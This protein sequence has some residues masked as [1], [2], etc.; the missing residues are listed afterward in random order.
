MTKR[1]LFPVISGIA[2][3]L[4]CTFAAPS[5][6]AQGPK[7]LPI[8]SLQKLQT[9]QTPQGDVIS[10][11]TIFVSEPGFGEKRF[12]SVPV[13][14]FQCLDSLST[15]NVFGFPGE[16]I[17]S[18]KF[19]LQYNNCMLKAVG[20]SKRG[21]LPQDT[22]VLADHFNFSWD[23]ADEPNYKV[24]TQGAPSANG[25][26]IT[27]SASSSLPL[28]KSPIEGFPLV[29]TCDDRV[30][31]PMIYVI[32]EVVGDANGGTCGAASD[33]II[34]VRDSI[35]WNDY[36]PAEVTPQMLARGFDPV[37]VGVFP[38]PV[39]PIA[40]PNDYGAAVVTITRRPRV[41]LLPNSQIIRP[42]LNDDSNYEVIF[43]I[44]TQ[45]GSNQLA[46][47]ELLFTN[48]VP[49]SVLRNIIIETDE[50]WLFV[51]T[52]NPRV[53]PGVQD[54]NRRI[55]YRQL[56]TPEQFFNIV[57][58]PQFL[59]APP[60]SYPTPGIYEGYVTMR[61]VDA[62]NSSVR[63]K[64]RL[65]V[66][67]NP[68]EPT[69]N[70]NQEP[71]NTRG[72]QL[73]FM[74]SAQAG[75]AD[76]T[77]LTF[78]TGIGATD[79]VDELFGEVEA[80]TPPTPGTFFA[81]FFPPSLAGFNGMIDG[82]EIYTRATA[83][84]RASNDEAS[85]DIRN[86]DAETIHTYCVRFGAGDPNNY[87]IVIEYDLNDIPRG[88]Q[89]FFRQNV[90][91]VESVIDMR[92][93]GANVG[94]TRRRVF[95]VDPSVTEFCMDYLLPRVVQFPEI[96]RGWNF[97]SLPVDP[98][99]PDPANVFSESTSG[100]IQFTS[101][102]Y[103][104]EET[105]VKV[106]LGYFVKYGG[107]LNL[108]VSGTPVRL[109]D[110]PTTPYDVRLFE[111]WNAVGGLSTE[112]EVAN[113]GFTAYQG[114]PIPNLI[115]EVYRYLT[116][117]GYEQVSRIDPGYGYWINVS[118]DAYYQLTPLAG[119]PKAVAGEK[120][121]RE[122][123][124]LNNLTISD[125]GQHSSRQLWF[126]NARFDD[127]RYEMP[128]VLGDDFFDVRF[129]NNGFVSSS[130]ERNAEHILSLNG[131]SYPV[132]ISVANPDAGY[133]VSDAETGAYIGEFRA[134]AA[135]AVTIANPATKRVKLT[136]VP[137]STI[138]LGNA[139]PN[140]TNDRATFSFAVPGERT[141]SIGLFNPL[142]EKVADLFEGTVTDGRTVEFSTADLDNGVY[143]YKMTTSSGETEIRHVVVAR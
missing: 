49:G 33:E 112:T 73:R 36:R 24:P 124:I 59:P 63:I 86:Y 123:Q 66:N 109:I 67:R 76:T 5:V 113:I 107:V 101:A 130:I 19:Q 104:K 35:W 6:M 8:L 46:V 14:A 97:V 79:S 21:T 106:G 75:L 81:R 116:S 30:Y 95:I 10:G 65:I 141:V 77:F 39:F 132:T 16:R 58:N 88:A 47:R 121:E 135:S 70:D 3:L 43:P 119:T 74:N 41:E 85:I 140:P 13:Y 1:Y 53:A 117:R 90:G 120:K 127:S 137:S 87:P 136:R 37:Q 29:P 2:L 125:N 26:R 48:N 118:G 82:R 91:G 69:L 72:I 27:V 9:T 84:P 18:F 80:A 89:L 23:V 138:N 51:D 4:L 134:G 57:A 133:I 12:L 142:G 64:V 42:D 110:E 94:G 61:S 62:Q 38:R 34:L 55:V 126:G 128:P 22:S 68:L 96:N 56:R 108:T 52:N 44:Q 115:G 7:G 139:F 45:F 15:D 32:F 40:T 28:P 99:D 83:V 111:G 54:G 93:E 31:T 11:P 60:S 25:S 105:E 78:G 17:Y 100:A 131:V 129:E 114:N 50:P 102:Q 98:S 92:T 20:V 122:F 103:S 71:I 143:V